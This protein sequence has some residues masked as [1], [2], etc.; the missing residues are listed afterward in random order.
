MGL[1]RTSIRQPPKDFG[2][3][4][5]Q[6]SG[7][8]YAPIHWPHSRPP[9]SFSQQNM[10]ALG[11]HC[12]YRKRVCHVCHSAVSLYM[13]LAQTSHA[14]CR[15]WEAFWVMVFVVRFSL[16][17][18]FPMSAEFKPPKKCG[19]L[20]IISCWSMMQ[21]DMIFHHNPEENC[22]DTLPFCSFLLDPSLEISVGFCMCMRGPHQN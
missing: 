15:F 13:L 20:S 18:D 4:Y 3:S 7:T 22:S 5:A 19:V 12:T 16:L 6:T 14:A 21:R 1:F 8:F 2:G 10:L 17:I 9:R 11:K